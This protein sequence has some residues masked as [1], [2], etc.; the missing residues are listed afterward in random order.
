MRLPGMHIS[1]GH[2]SPGVKGSAVGHSFRLAMSADLGTV[3]A[4]FRNRISR[5]EVFAEM[6]RVFRESDCLMRCWF[7]TAFMKT[8]FW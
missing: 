3:A 1:K 7:L 5:L 2:A 6:S 8:C 4:S